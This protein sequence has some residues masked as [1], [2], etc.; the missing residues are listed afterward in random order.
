MNQ[1]VLIIEDDKT[2]QEYVTDL[3]SK[4]GY[5]VRTAST[6]AQGLKFLDS[7]PPDLVLLDLQLPDLSGE[8]VLSQL[9]KLYPALPVLVLTAK[10]STQDKVNTLTTGADDY[11]TKPFDSEELVARI[12]ARLRTSGENTN[13]LLKLADL[14]VDTQKVTVTRAGKEISLTPHE[15]N[16]LVYLL[17]NTGR[18]LSRD[19]ILNRV[20][21]YT[22][23]VETRVVDVYMGYLRKKIDSGSKQ[24]L[25]HS[26][27]GFGYTIKAS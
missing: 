5:I 18:V 6:G 23:D 15:Y 7:T 26:L 25:I 24:K 4:N 2:V 22:M 21:A 3:L 13:H 10:N 14:E 16:L 1:T 8:S 17:Q 9:K 27:R 12:K 20:W 11:V 19:M